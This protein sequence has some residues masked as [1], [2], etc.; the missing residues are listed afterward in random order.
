MYS[1]RIAWLI[2]ITVTGIT[3]WLGYEM[4][5]SKFDY[6]FEKFF[7]KENEETRLY[8]KFRGQFENDYDFL[9]IG[10]ENDE[11]IFR[12]EFLEKVE[13]FSDTLSAIRDIKKVYS[14]T[15]LKLPILQGVGISYKK[16]LR[17][18][19]REGLKKDSA[20]IYETREFVGS[21][22]ASDGRSLCLVLQTKEKMAK[23]PSDVLLSRIESATASFGFNRVHMAGKINAQYVYLKRMQKEIVF[24]LTAAVILVILLLAVTF[25]SVW[26]VLFPIT[27]VLLSVIWQLG[28]MHLAGKRIDILTTLLPTILFVVGISNVIHIISKYIEELRAGQSK[29]N[30]IRITMKE[31]GLAASLTSVTTALGFVSLVTSH[32]IPI[33][34]F[35][36]YTALGVLIAFLLT[37]TVGPSVLVL[38]PPPRITKRKTNDRIWRNLLYRQLTWTLRHPWLVTGIMVIVTLIASAGIFRLKVNSYLLEDLRPHEPL[39]QEFTWFETNYSGSRPF[40]M[41]IT[42]S[43][44]TKNIFTYEAAKQVEILEAGIHKHFGVGF[45]Q[46][47]LS[48]FRFFHRALNSGKNSYF[49]LPETRGSF[50]TLVYKMRTF[51]LTGLSEWKRFV[52]ADLRTVRIS[53]KMYDVGSYRMNEMEQAFRKEMALQTDTALLEYQ[54]TGSARLVDQN[55]SFLSVSMM[56]G[57]G[58]AFAMIACIFAVMFRSLRMLFIAFIPNTV[59]LFVVAGF[60]G[61]AGIDL[62][63][64]TSM[65]FTIAFG[66]A[67]DNTIHFLSRYRI[68]RMAGKSDLYAI[69]RSYLSTGKAIIIT[70]VILYAGFTPMIT[71]SFLS[72]YYFGL[73]IFITLLIGL[74]ADLF[75]LPVLLVFLKKKR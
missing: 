24:F 21:F 72:V 71:S 25:Q 16:V 40:E 27:V 57:L 74:L 45:I 3:V 2:L 44:T 39:R 73:L 7:P 29:Q 14:P 62:K 33:R 32:I 60:M 68:E 11:G 49:R 18:H 8:E 50:D 64:S 19:D 9:L 61:W 12:P 10:I 31:V 54:F 38:F 70:S 59:P 4:R 26:N 23:K 13:R 1:K 67:V 65:I 5:Q 42:I 53:G 63:V 28:I 48:Q 35:G 47:P 55:I 43:D 58:L 15:D 34:E 56:K 52:T 6:A 22:F 30:A 69:K 17:I 46:S 66:I 37:L 51:G 20:R 41:V 75:L 36:L